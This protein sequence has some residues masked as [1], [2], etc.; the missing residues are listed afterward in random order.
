MPSVEQ[1]DQRLLIHRWGLVRLRARAKNELQHLAMN[2]GAQK[3][4]RL[5][6]KA[7]QKL[8]RE[9]PLADAHQTGPRVPAPRG[10]SESEAGW[11]FGARTMPGILRIRWRA[12]LGESIVRQSFHLPRRRVYSTMYRTNLGSAASEI[13]I[14]GQHVSSM[15]TWR[16]T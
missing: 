14:C 13:V 8:L 12:A 15:R 7:G 3:K 11:L 5:W 10:G 4:A 1:R 2:K 9:L 6:S 16:G